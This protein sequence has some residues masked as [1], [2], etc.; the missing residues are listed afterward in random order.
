MKPE[1]ENNLYSP[2]VVMPHR[3]VSLIKDGKVLETQTIEITAFVDLER[4]E[5]KEAIKGVLLKP[6]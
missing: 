1:T 6:K 4:Y 5:V 3:I 2:F